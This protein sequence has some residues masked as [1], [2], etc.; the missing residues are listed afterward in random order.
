[1]STNGHVNGSAKKVEHQFGWEIS[2]KIVPETTP[3]KIDVWSVFS[4]LAGHVPKDALNLGQG[5]LSLRLGL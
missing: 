1:M 4:P 2:D 3:G 5:E